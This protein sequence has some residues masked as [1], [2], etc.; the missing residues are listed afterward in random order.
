MARTDFRIPGVILVRGN[1]LYAMVLDSLD[2]PY[3][4]RGRIR[5]R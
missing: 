5:N 4:V 3:V 1:N 2:V